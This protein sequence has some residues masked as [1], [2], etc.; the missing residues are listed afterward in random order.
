MK[1]KILHLTQF[2]GVGGLEKVLFLLIQ[3]QLKAGHEVELVVYDYEQAWVEHFRKNGIKVNTS[4][5]KAEGYDKKLLQFL[6]TLVPGRD[7]VHTHD[8]NPLMY[9]APLKFLHTLK[10]K[11]FPKLIHTAHGM[12]HLHKRPVTKL[13][14]KLCSFMTNATIGVSTAVCDYYLNLG[15]SPKKVININ[16]GTKILETQSLRDLARTRLKSDFNIEDHQSVWVSVARVVPLKDQKI[17]CELATQ[18]PDSQFL[19]IGPSGDEEYWKDVYSS[20]PSNV[21]MPGARSD[22]NELLQGSDFFISASHH[23]GIPVSVLEAGAVGIPCLLS[24]IPGHQVIQKGFEQPIALY[25]KTGDLSDLKE[26]SSELKNN[27]SLASSVGKALHTH[28]KQN[29]SSE[30]MYQRYLDVYLG[31]QCFKS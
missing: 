22:I 31:R 13:Y 2:L 9:A 15:V 21:H 30:S 1:L 12:D 10:G 27:K 18:N 11:P 17:I 19:L 8:L 20:K 26:K 6:G 25:F 5:K 16:N 23:E 24:D 4:Y 3:E 28:V 29:F 7:V 14:E